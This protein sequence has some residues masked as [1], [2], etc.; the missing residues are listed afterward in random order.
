MA[1]NEKLPRDFL[2]FLVFEDQKAMGF[3]G[4]FLPGIL[5]HRMLTPGNENP[6]IFRGIFNSFL[7][8]H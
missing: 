4:S 7:V 8:K 5:V 3:R 1:T 6:R 2:V